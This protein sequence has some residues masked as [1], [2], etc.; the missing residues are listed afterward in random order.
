MTLKDI[1]KTKIIDGVYFL[2]IPEANVKILCSTPAD[3]IKHLKKSKVVKSVNK[4]GVLFE[5]GPN[6]ILLSDTPVQNGQFSNLSEFPVLQMLYKQGM[7][8]PGHINNTGQRPQLIGTEDQVQSQLEY[9]FRGNYGLINEEELTEVGVPPKKAAEMMRMKLKF[10]YGKIIPSKELIDTLVVHEEKV[11]IRN[12]VFIQRKSSNVYDISYKETTVRVDLNLKGGERYPPPYE[13]KF[14]KVKNEYFSVI[15]SGDGDGWNINLPSM[16]G[17]VQSQGKFYLIDAGPNILYALNSLG[18]G[19]NNIEGLFHTHAHDD[20]FAGLTTLIRLD[21]RI[22]YYA[23]PHVRASVEKKLCALM[24]MKKGQ[25]GQLFDTHDLEVEKWNKVG[26][27]EV[28]P[29]DSPHP[30]ETNIFL[31]RKYW[32]GGHKVYSHMADIASFSVLENM[33]NE[34]RNTPGISKEYYNKVK[35]FY[36]YP[37][38][39]KKI[40]IGG[41]PIHGNPNDFKDDFSK[42]LILSHYSG[43]VSADDKKLGKTLPFGHQ[44]VLINATQDYN[45]KTA[46]EYLTLRYPNVEKLY[47]S[48]LIN[49]DVVQFKKD[50]VII[51]EGSPVKDVYLVLSGMLKSK[52]NEQNSFSEHS[53]GV[54]IEEIAALSSKSSNETYTA[55]GYVSAL[56]IPFGIYYNF[57]TSNELIKEIESYQEKIT[58][59]KSTKLLRDLISFNVLQKISNN[60]T[61][62]VAKKGDRLDCEKDYICL[63]ESGVLD[64]MLSNEKLK[65]VKAGEFLGESCLFEEKPRPLHA[66]I[67]EDA[68]YY[69]IPKDV[70]LK[71]PMIHWK[72]IEGSDKLLA[73]IL[74]GQKAA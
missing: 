14:K 26:L 38:T 56:K 44:T 23:T 9:I 68:V 28:M 50:E 5:T 58:F 36:L 27:L 22:K 47:L 17:I 29:V 32:I 18:I 13:L 53:S 63:V 62:K 45:R 16:G 25:F 43:R 21:H 40:D 49:C 52:T 71:V 73:L 60:M 31:F 20:H 1:I 74:A 6:A 55:D 72:L 64:I 3:I 69:S 59:L 34:D 66:M 10:A 12:D 41:G 67:S 35:N 42:N 2:D 15:N 54:M 7:M 33:L 70:L 4:N 19:V 11:E 48:P 51:A 61:R 65:S 24:N 57:V 46:F 30:I 37:C 39:M 8:L